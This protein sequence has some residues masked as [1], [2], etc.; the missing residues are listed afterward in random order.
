MSRIQDRGLGKAPGLLTGGTAPAGRGRQF[1]IQLL[2][3]QPVVY[4][5]QYAIYGLWGQTSGAR[6]GVPIYGVRGQTSGTGYSA[7]DIMEVYSGA[8]R[9]SVLYVLANFLYLNC[10]DGDFPLVWKSPE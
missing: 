1:R 7:L 5:R 2:I 10:G 4:E 6:H 8:G 3:R 9:C